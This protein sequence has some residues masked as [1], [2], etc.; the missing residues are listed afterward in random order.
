MFYSNNLLIII[1]SIDPYYNI[2]HRLVSY[3]TNQELASSPRMGLQY[4]AQQRKI[5]TICH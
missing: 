5:L 1:C 4:I 3:Q 2:I